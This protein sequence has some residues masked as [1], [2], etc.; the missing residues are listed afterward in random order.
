M[1]REDTFVKTSTHSGVGGG[2]CDCG[3]G[4]AISFFLFRRHECI[5][6][7]AFQGHETGKLSIRHLGRYE[8]GTRMK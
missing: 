6:L 3:N 1:H 2:G 7:F 8:N 5:V 4:A